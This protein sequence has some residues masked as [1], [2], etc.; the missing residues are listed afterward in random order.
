MI[1]KFS[2]YKQYLWEI[3][4]TNSIPIIY[5]PKSINQRKDVGHF[6]IDFIL[7][8]GNISKSIM[9]LVERV[10][11][12]GFA[13]KLE[14]KTMKHTNE[15]LKELNVP[16]YTCNT[17]ASCEKNTNKNFNGWLEEIY[18]RKPILQI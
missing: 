6:E 8:S 5:R 16:L 18:L 17:Y 10:T 2:K 13:I 15:K 1:K 9:A 3:S 7:S 11:R 12:K 14:N 4:K